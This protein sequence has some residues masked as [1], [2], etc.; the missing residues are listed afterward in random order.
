MKHYHIV[1]LL[2]KYF[3]INDIKMI[4]VW[5]IAHFHLLKYK[6]KGLKM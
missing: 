3:P 2:W 1:S 4:V 6:Y 5:N